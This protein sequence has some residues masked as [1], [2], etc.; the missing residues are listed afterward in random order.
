MALSIRTSL[1]RIVSETEWQTTHEQL[2]AKEK[3]ATRERDALSAER[4]RQPM[5]RIQKDYIFAGAGGPA[6]L[7]DLFEGRR[8]LALYHFMGE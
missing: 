2:L 5:Y 1:P 7:R 6:H 4:R 8:Q 3:A